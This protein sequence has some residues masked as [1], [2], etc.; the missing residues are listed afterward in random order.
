[1]NLGKRVH[2]QNLG[3]ESAIVQFDTGFFYGLNEVGGRI[4]ELIREN[5]TREQIISTIAAEFDA[6]ENSVASDYDAFVAELTAEKIL[7]A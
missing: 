5:K 1:M 2:L 7:E 4:I 6:A 3:D